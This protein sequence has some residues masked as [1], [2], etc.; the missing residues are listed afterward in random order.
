MTNGTRVPFFKNSQVL[1]LALLQEGLV[2][3]AHSDKQSRDGIIIKIGQQL[4]VILI[5]TIALNHTIT[6][7]AAIMPVTL[8]DHTWKQIQALLH[9]QKVS[10][11]RLS[12]SSSSTKN[13]IQKHRTRVVSAP[14]PTK[15]SVQTE[16][17]DL[18]ASSEEEEEAEEELTKDQVKCMWDM[19]DPTPLNIASLTH[20]NYEARKP[21]QPHYIAR[22]NNSV[23]KRMRWV[24]STYLDAGLTIRYQDAKSVGKAIK[25]V[26]SKFPQARFTTDYVRGRLCT[27]LNRMVSRKKKVEQMASKE[28]VT[29]GIDMLQK[30]AKKLKT[31]AVR[32]RR[33]ATTGGK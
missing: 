23:Q 3:I 24:I 12:S 7:F 2:L 26:K 17:V 18:F 9:K 11:G 6:C 8:D 27:K 15:L 19:T 33:S 25:A 4:V 30:A 13:L 1:G 21:G 29:E 5:Q 28:A 22:L 20:K 16:D 32:G 31:R 14:A 10:A